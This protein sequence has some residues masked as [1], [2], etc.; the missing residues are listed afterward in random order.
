M[1]KRHGLS[2]VIPY[3]VDIT[4]DYTFPEFHSKSNVFKASTKIG[5]FVQYLFVGRQLSVNWS[6]AVG[7]QKGGISFIISMNTLLPFIVFCSFCIRVE[8]GSYFGF[9]GGGFFFFQGGDRLDE[10]FF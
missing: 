2:F 5:S 4:A 8:A 9:Q 6:T 7:Q 1:I 3:W 10:I